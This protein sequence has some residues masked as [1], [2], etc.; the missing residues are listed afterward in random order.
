M[1]KT[2]EIIPGRLF[3]RGT[4]SKRSRKAVQ[5]LVTE[6]KLNLII[7]CLRNC[8]CNQKAEG[9]TV[10]RYGLSDSKN[11]DFEDLDE[12]AGL[13]AASLGAGGRVLIHCNAGRNRACTTAA[14]TYMKHMG[15]TG[16]EALKHVRSVRPRAVANPAMEAY[17]LGLDD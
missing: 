15:T 16:R 7:C 10:F 4:L 14:R 5:E 13:A 1:L 8:D 6:L 3:T 2:Y 11:T 17:L 12:A 9:V